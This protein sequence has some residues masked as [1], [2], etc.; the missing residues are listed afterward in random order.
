M[1]NQLPHCGEQDEY[2]HSMY[3]D[4]QGSY[5]MEWNTMILDTTWRKYTG[6]SSDRSTL[7]HRGKFIEFI[8]KVFIWINKM[9]PLSR[10]NESKWIIFRSTYLITF[11]SKNTHSS[12]LIL[13][14][15]AQAVPRH[16]VLLSTSLIYYCQSPTLTTNLLGEEKGTLGKSQANCLTQIISYSTD[17]WWEFFHI[18]GKEEANRLSI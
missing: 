10:G 18:N 11:R 3:H 7:S 17:E 14:R 8:T 2:G 15:S 16:T 1:S 5:A 12:S 4:R 6:S 13:T 9:P